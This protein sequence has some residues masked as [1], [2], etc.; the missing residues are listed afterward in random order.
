MLSVSAQALEAGAAKV[1]ITPGLGTP[2]NGY[3]ARLGQGAAAVHD[4]I[5]ARA[6]YL[7]DGQTRLLLV[8]ADLCVIN[9][10]LRD[11]ALEL[12]PRD[13]PPENIFL[14]ATHNHS[15]TGGMVRPL[16]FRSISGRFMPEV[17]EAAAQKF[18]EVMRTA[19]G[20]RQRAAIGYA[21]FQQ[22][23]LSRNRR[24]PDGPVDTQVGV[25]RVENADGRPIAVMANFAAH[26]TN[27]PEEDALSVS[28]DYCG[29]YYA[30]LEALLGESA[31]AL[32]TNGAEGDQKCAAPHGE[33]GWAKTEAV[34]RLLAQRVNEAAQKIRCDESAL[35]VASAQVTL[36][37]TLADSFLP[38]DTTLKT[39][40]INDLLLTFFPGEPCVDIGLELRKR[41]LA[42]G[43]GAQFSVGLSNDHLMYFV[44]RSIYS[45]TGYESSMNFYGPGIEDFFYREFSKLMSRGTPEPEPERPAEPEIAALPGSRRIT[46]TGS[47]Y[48]IG[49]MRGMAFAE[50]IRAHYRD[51]VWARVESKA[52]VPKTGLWNLA[53]PFLNQTPLA[54][55]FL[56]FNARPLLKGLPD[57]FLREVEG[58]ADACALPFDAVWLSQCAPVFEVQARSEDIY[59]QP[60]C[61]MFAL[62][63]K[64]TERDGVLIGRN[65]DWPAAGALVVEDV[66]PATGRR[67]VAIGFPWTAG[68]FTGMNDAGLV[69]C[70]ERVEALGT[71]S[72][73]GP[74]IE[75]ALRQTLQTAG[76]LP[77]ALAQ[78]QAASHLRGFHA[79]VADAASLDARIIEYG[80]TQ[81][82]RAPVEGLLLGIDP[83]SPNADDSG[84]KRY[85]RAAELIG[86]KQALA[87]PRVQEI[88]SDADPAQNG[89]ARIFNEQTR[90][91]V[92]FQPRIRQIRVAF[93]DENG[94]PGPYTVVRLGEVDD[95]QPQ[96]ATGSSRD[97]A[98]TAT[99]Q[100]RRASSSGTRSSRK[101]G[102]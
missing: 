20:A 18:A 31:I 66:K 57:D 51:R 90:C 58:M 19:I 10:E 49:Y 50:E 52:W 48:A 86:D 56:A 62:T 77:E 39:I 15:G 88:L 54:L 76:T 8:A 6:L 78:L 2:L 95:V 91:S 92:V 17:L 24:V 42:R 11:R 72:L 94:K 41:S 98:K 40:E 70:A 82:V 74:P 89:T 79:L 81:V 33:D 23:D 71:P 34:G 97:A 47:A 84:S 13:V 102:S 60:Y 59:R 99:Q 12:A 7:E 67:F 64:R 43:Y 46:L 37:K 68:V 55:P 36:P 87:A 25:I 38:Q 21:T 65:F 30:E 27:V 101:E 32:F 53:P 26:P 44:P 73:T 16:I 80:A 93:P 45:T 75:M 4:P 96:A 35:R 14:V 1:D 69:L 9:R 100:N 22:N 5:T 28:A 3:G 83:A 29:F 63:G 85:A 61:T